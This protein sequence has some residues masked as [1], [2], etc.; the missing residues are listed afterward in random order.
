MARLHPTKNDISANRRQA[1][2]DLL[3][4]R[5]SDALDLAAQTKQAHW[6]VK[7][8]SFIALHELFDKIYTEVAVAVDDIAERIVTLGGTAKGTVPVTAKHSTLPAYPL[9]IADGL[10]HCQAMATALSSFGKQARAAIDDADELA[11]KDTADLFT[12]I[13]RGVDKNLWFVEAHIQA[14]K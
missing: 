14:K 11:D 10:A 13:S 2:V 12:G 8:P 6:N 4:A 9:D 1:V 7:G 5:L 3:Q